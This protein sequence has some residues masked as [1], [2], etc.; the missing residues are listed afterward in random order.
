MTRKEIITHFIKFFIY[1]L[2]Q[3]KNSDVYIENAEID[4]LDFLE[5]YIKNEH[6]NFSP[7]KEVK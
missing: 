1:D 3:G 6:Y 4:L 5:P 7:F 2:K